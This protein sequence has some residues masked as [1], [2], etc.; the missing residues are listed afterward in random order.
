MRI[1]L[2]AQLFL[3]TASS[4]VAEQSQCARVYENAVRN[5]TV[6]ERNLVSRVNFFNLHCE[7]NGSVRDS[8][9]AAG[10]E[11]PDQLAFSSRA[12]TQEARLQDFC[13]AGSVDRLF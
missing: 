3:F 1:L 4:V 9:Q 8:S 10:I 11:L 6:E 12:A 13:R 7:R 5:F 2:I